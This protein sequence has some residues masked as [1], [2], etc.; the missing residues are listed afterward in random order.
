MVRK[1]GYLSRP[2]GPAGVA[3]IAYGVVVISETSN[4]PSRPRTG[5]VLLVAIS[6]L[7]G[8]STVRS[9]WPWHHAPPA[10]EPPVNELVVVAAEGATPHVLTQ[11]WARN[12]LNVDL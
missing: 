6:L 7:A 3:G 10:A 5:F 12:V 11:T 1:S 8:C 2:S 4:P 9:W